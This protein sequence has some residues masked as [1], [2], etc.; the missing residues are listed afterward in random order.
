MSS[1]QSRLSSFLFGL[2]P[3]LIAAGVIFV[4]VVIGEKAVQGYEMRQ[5]A[6]ALQR[7]IEQLRQENRGLSQELDYLR[8]DEYIEKVAREELGLVRPGDVAVAIVQPQNK[9][10]Q[11]PA[12]IPTPP[13]TPTP[14]PERRDVPNW[15]R[16]LSL[17]TG[18]D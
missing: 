6:R 9:K 12:P 14:E 11:L 4:L 10:D 18:R 3:L 13:P 15:Q 16:W 2:L 1:Q 5:E 8:S 7:R 17:F